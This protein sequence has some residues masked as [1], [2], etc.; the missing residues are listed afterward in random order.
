M[1]SDMVAGPILIH[2]AAHGGEPRVHHHGIHRLQRGREGGREVGERG[3]S[4]GRERAR[5]G[6]R[7]VGERRTRQDERSRECKGGNHEDAQ[8]PEHMELGMRVRLC[9]WGPQHLQFEHTSRL[10][11]TS[12]VWKVVG[13]SSRSSHWLKVRLFLTA[14]ESGPPYVSR[15]QATVIFRHRWAFQRIIN[16]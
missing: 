4:G 15:V 2:A 12:V 13:E 11:S 16:H 5:E 14:V 9:M 3:E 1:Q 6:G 10:Y 7:K 8:K